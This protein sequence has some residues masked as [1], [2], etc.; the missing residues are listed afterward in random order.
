[1]NWSHHEGS[2]AISS[3]LPLYR[4]RKLTP[5]EVVAA[6]YDRIAAAG[7]DAVWIT[8]VSHDAALAQAQELERNADADRLPLFGIP[9]A[10]KDCIDAAGLPT[11]AAC[12]DFT[13]VPA[14]SAFVVDRLL[15]AG[16]ILIGKTNLDQFATGLVGVRS[17]YGACRC[18]FDPTRISGGSSSGSAVAVST[19]LVSFALGTDTAGSGRV[20]A[21]FT[22][23]VGLKPSHGQLSNRGVVPA[24]RSLDHVSVF[25]L[26][27]DDAASVL[28][29]AAGHDAADPYSDPAADR[30]NMIPSDLFRDRFRFGI[31]AK[32]ELRFFG[33]GTMEAA[34]QA[35]LGEL[36]ALGGERVEIDYGPFRSAGELL[37]SGPFLAE[38]YGFL[39]NFL[40]EHPEAF[41]P[42]TRKVLEG[43]AMFTAVDAFAAI[44]RREELRRR[45]ATIFR[46]VDVLAIPT[47]PTHPTFAELEADP[48]QL[49][50]RLGYYTQFANLLGCCVAAVPAGFRTDGLPFGLSLAAPAGRDAAL[51]GL[52]AVLHH[53]TGTRL[54]ATP[55]R[56]VPAQNAGVA[57]A[58]SG[59]VRL[60]V[61]GAHMRGLPANVQL[62]ERSAT[63]VRA[64]R[65]EA[66]CRLFA[67]PDAIPPKPGMI[68]SPEGGSA[69]DVEV[70]DVP[71]SQFGSFVAL[72]PSP[73]SIGTVRLEDG[74]TVKG[75]LCETW[76]TIGAE[77]ITSLGG[78]RA[79][80]RRGEERAHE[81]PK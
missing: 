50:F 26:T 66:A 11:T 19:G 49:N 60:A 56:F 63:F 40:T 64:C 68:R 28:R 7:D 75:F 12:P 38:R 6:I 37:Y 16:A 15:S 70:W 77:E 47:A 17:P 39:R 2:L 24:C 1:M 29:V 79:Y 48:I 4:E 23:I 71:I 46:N 62:L 21:A 72:V 58:E 20:P 53:R 27:V 54:G 52:A 80:L 57:R 41:H 31:P 34:Y 65:T 8:K 13:Y 3:L 81:K 33:D 76:A 45:A 35:A 73:L 30:V 67:F 9:F 44:E 55:D 51:F 69:I 14:E 59:M 36:E 74:E 32:H 78:W 42:V 10:I 22:N 61:V 5:S 25:G 18:P 43:G